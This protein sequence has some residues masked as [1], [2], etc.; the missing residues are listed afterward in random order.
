MQGLNKS[1]RIPVGS[2]PAEWFH[3]LSWTRM[4]LLLFK[5]PYIMVGHEY[6]ATWTEMVGASLRRT[7]ILHSHL[8]LWRTQNAPV[9]TPARNICVR[10]ITKW[11]PLQWPQQPTSHND[12]LNPER[13]KKSGAIFINT[14]PLCGCAFIH[15]HVYFNWAWLKN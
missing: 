1:P 13:E 8:W 4:D 11:I 2:Q 3:P 15:G 9:L 10:E 12:H 7:S 14:Q 5:C 6:P